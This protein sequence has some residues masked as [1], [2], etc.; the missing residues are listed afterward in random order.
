MLFVASLDLWWRHGWSKGSTTITRAR[1]EK[2]RI[3]NT[4]MSAG[5]SKSVNTIFIQ[6]TFLINILNGHKNVIAQTRTE[7]VDI[8]PVRLVCSNHGYFV[9]VELFKVKVSLNLNHFQW[10]HLGRRPVTRSVSKP[11]WVNGRARLGYLY[12]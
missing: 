8:Q 10:M 3:G 1:D 4:V 5:I 2:R 11:V 6:N 9:S 7:D 12:L